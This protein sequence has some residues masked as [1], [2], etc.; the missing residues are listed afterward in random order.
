ML[1]GVHKTQRMASAV[2]DRYHK[3]GNEFLNLIIRVIS[4][5]TWVS[6]V[7]VETRAVK[8][9]DALTFTKPTKNV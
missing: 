1:T 3:D 7:D 9:M 6:F 8:A 5:E 2:C 4:D